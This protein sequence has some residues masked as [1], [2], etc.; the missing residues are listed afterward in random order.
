MAES[1]LVHNIN[2]IGKSNN[3]CPV[4][5]IENIK[6]VVSFST[7]RYSSDFIPKAHNLD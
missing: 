7:I 4:C 5:I 6:Q 1:L 2:M 3:S